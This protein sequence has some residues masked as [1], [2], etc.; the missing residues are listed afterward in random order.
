MPRQI[1]ARADTDVLEADIRFFA[2][3]SVRTLLRG[4]IAAFAEP[5]EPPWRAFERLL[6]HAHETWFHQPRH[7]DPVFERDGWRCAV[8]ACSSRRN[9]HDHHIVFRS[10]GGTNRR[11]NRITVCA[12]HHLRGLHTG[13]VRA[14]GGAPD[15]ITW[16]LGI[17]G[18][19]CLLR[20]RGERYLVL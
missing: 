18:G 10:R 2:P 20:L 11:E 15:G 13:R 12:W 16:E 4:A 19:R 5:R 17:R 8:P 6:E 9:L 1:G 14:W 7:R 3:W